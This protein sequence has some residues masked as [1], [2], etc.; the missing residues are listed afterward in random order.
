MLLQMLR[1]VPGTLHL[2]TA[3]QRPGRA[4]LLYPGI[5][6]VNLFCDFKGVIDLDTKIP[7]RTLNFLVAQK[8]PRRAEIPSAAVDQSYLRPPHAVRR[9]F[10]TVETDTAHPF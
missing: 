3:G 4:R 8:Q 6:D 2:S 7:H 9:E 5:S 1:T 10:Q